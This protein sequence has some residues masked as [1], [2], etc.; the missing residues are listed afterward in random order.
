MLYG[1]DSRT[2][3]QQ[4][5]NITG[6]TLALFYLAYAWLVAGMFGASPNSALL[7]TTLFLSVVIVLNG[8]LLFGTRKPPLH[9]IRVASSV[10]IVLMLAPFAFAIGHAGLTGN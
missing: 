4:L 2:A 10:L 3:G 9:W 5:Q 8:V 6:A 1:E 7:M